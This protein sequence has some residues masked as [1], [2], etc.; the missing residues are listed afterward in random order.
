M[1]RGS[2]FGRMYSSSVQQAG[3][4]NPRNMGRARNLVSTRGI[5]MTRV[6]RPMPNQNRA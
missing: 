4:R 3:S 1:S 6:N 2:N 5:P